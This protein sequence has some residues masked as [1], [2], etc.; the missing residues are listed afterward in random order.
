MSLVYD[1]LKRV[2]LS[3]NAQLYSLDSDSTVDNCFEKLLRAES[4]RVFS[5]VLSNLA[6]GSTRPKTVLVCSASKGEGATT[7]GIG[8]ALAAAD[9]RAGEVLLI[10]GNF[11]SPTASKVFRMEDGGLAEYL[12]GDL[13][14]PGIKRTAIPALSLLASGRIRGDH[15]QGMET[16]KFRILLDKLSPL[17]QF[18][19]VDGPAINAHPESVLYAPQVDRTLLI[20]HAGETRGPVVRNALSKLSAAGCNKVGVILNRRSFAIPQSVYKRL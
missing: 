17:Y 9:K 3:V 7:V 20:I 4:R 13:A 5:T 12:A 16:P 2:G 1:A 15:I 14:N 18:I 10:D 19:L 6:G 11:H 8:L